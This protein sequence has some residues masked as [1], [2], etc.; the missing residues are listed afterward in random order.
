MR[1]ALLGKF[2]AITDDMMSHGT[3]AIFASS[4]THST[5]YSN[6]ALGRVANQEY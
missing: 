5:K 4:R 1:V 3:R 6:V 2:L